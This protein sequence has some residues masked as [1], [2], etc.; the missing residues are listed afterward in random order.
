MVPLAGGQVSNLNNADTL[1]RFL[2]H[3]E[4]LK[5]M[6]LDSYECRDMG[7]TII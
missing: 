7:V 4:T 6:R 5:S 2:R 1:S 3:F